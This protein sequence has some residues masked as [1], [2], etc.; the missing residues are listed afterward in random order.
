MLPPIMV[1][2]RWRNEARCLLNLRQINAAVVSQAIANRHPPGEKVDLSEVILCLP[3]MKLPKCP[4]GGKYL[5]GAI[6][7]VPSCSYHV[8]LEAQVAEP[9]TTDKLLVV[10]SE[11]ATTNTHTDGGT[12]G[13][14]V[15]PNP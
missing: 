3:R 15:A 5:V 14:P 4:S 1:W 8:G 9:G 12:N 2:V 7:E 13:Q 10:D 6:G 11:R